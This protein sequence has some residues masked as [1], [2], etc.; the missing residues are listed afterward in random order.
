MAQNVSKYMVISILNYVLF[1]NLFLVRNI[2]EVPPK[3]V[4]KYLSFSIWD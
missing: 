4:C 1:L 2:W 3:T